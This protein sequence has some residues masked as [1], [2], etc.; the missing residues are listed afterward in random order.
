M[1]LVTSGIPYLSSFG[2]TDG[3]DVRREETQWNAFFPQRLYLMKIIASPDIAGQLPYILLAAYIQQD[4]VTLTGQRQRAQQP[5]VI[6][7]GCV[8]D[9]Q[10]VEICL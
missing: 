8:G 9:Y 2:Q 10:P 4:L 3:D 7:Q 1:A 5:G 6:A